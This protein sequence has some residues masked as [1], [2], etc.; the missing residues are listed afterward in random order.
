ML[1]AA[2]TIACPHPPGLVQTSAVH[3]LT[4]AGAAVLTAAD[5][6]PRQV[7]GCVMPVAQGPPQTKTCTKVLSWTGGQAARLTVDGV[8]VLLD[9]GFEARTDG[10]EPA[11]PPAPPA[12]SQVPKLKAA[13][14]QIRLKGE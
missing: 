9:Q 4:V 2:S 3:R 5:V 10:L 12:A 7:I 1:T 8:P 6:V 14:N 13:A 11:A